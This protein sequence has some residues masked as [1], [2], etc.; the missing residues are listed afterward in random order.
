MLL[1]VGVVATTLFAA[2]L[3]PTLRRPSE[4]YA[5]A[6][7]PKR[8][9]PTSTVISKGFRE[10]VHRRAIGI[11]PAEA[12]EVVR[13]VLASAES[14]GVD[15]L[16]LVSLIEVESSYRAGVVSRAG[17][18]G[19]MQIAPITGVHVARRNE[20][21]WLGPDALFDATTNVEVGARYF[22]ELVERFRDIET[23]L[24]AYNIGPEKVAERRAA[25][26]PVATGPFAQRVMA[27]YRSVRSQWGERE[28]LSYFGRLWQIEGPSASIEI[29]L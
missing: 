14:T 26:D 5:E 22:V 25:G 7:P 20:I 8:V 10:L 21:A 11:T 23:V 15:P 19:L 18:I 3:G 29:S 2:P 9:Q 4:A 6:A 27:V 16:L 13:V 12:D 28:M 1:G 17:A 24:E